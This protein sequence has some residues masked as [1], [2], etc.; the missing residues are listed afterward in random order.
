MNRKHRSLVRGRLV[1]EGNVEYLLY[2][3]ML[4]IWPDSRHP[5][6]G[7]LPES[8][9][10][11][12]AR[13]RLEQ[14]LIKAVREA[15]VRT[16]W[17]EPDEAYENALLHFTR[18]ILDRPEESPFL[19]DLTRFAASVAPTGR[20]NSLARL[21]LQLTSAGIPDVYRGDELP[22]FSLVDPDNR[23]PIDYRQRAH[24]LEEIEEIERCEA[25]TGG[26]LRPDD[27]RFKLLILRRLLDIRRRHPK[28][29][30]EGSYT[31]LSVRG[32]RADQ[33]VAF[34]RSFGGT[35]LVVVVPR[36][37]WRLRDGSTERVDTLWGT[38]EVSLPETFGERQ[39]QL[40]LS[41]EKLSL[42]H[43]APTLRLS[44]LFADLPFAV[45]LSS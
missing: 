19:G 11:D 35:R 9:W 7:E 33:I 14:Y 26:A 32:K 23:R 15:K 21:V 28:L 3:T 10:L 27:P 40:L 12:S 30:H 22:C 38:T 13:R 39:F 36:F 4:G 31:P 6:S 41:R 2:Q 20:W 42:A 34:G 1:P 45:L 25:E 16:S 29:F 5:E 8:D 17:T 37:F 44:D 24:L 43:G 18:S